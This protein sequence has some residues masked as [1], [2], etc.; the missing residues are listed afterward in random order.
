MRSRLKE[1][2]KPAQFK[3]VS[4]VERDEEHRTYSV[5]FTDAQG[6]VRKIDWTLATTNTGTLKLTPQEA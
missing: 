1:L 2:E 3:A 5:S 6:A 4:D